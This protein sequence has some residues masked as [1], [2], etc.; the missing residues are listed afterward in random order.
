MAGD[1]CLNPRLLLENHL[2]NVCPPGF[3]P[4]VSRSLPLLLVFPRDI[5]SG[6]PVL[7]SDIRPS[8]VPDER[9]DTLLPTLPASQVQRCFQRR[10]QGGRTASSLQ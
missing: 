8:A 7:V 10:V 1:E 9:T 6:F 5:Q 2:P 4:S 3:P